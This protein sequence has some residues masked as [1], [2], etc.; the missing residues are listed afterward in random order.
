MTGTDLDLFA[1]AGDG[2]LPEHFG[3]DEHGRAFVEAPAF[4][5][6]MQY[7]STQKALQIVDTDE[8]GQLPRLTPGG[9]QLI[10]VIYEDGIW[11]LIFR[12]TLP[13]AKSIKAR[14][15]AILRE[16]R[17]T[18]VV[19]T[20]QPLAAL[21]NRDLALRI[22]AEADRADAAEAV[23]AVLAPAASAWEIFR[24]TGA[25]VTVG[26]AAKFLIQNADK[27]TGRTRLYETLREL[28]W[29]FKR[30]REPVGGAITAGYVEIEG[31]KP[32]LVKGTTEKRTGGARTRL[33]GDGLLKLAE[34]FGIELDTG[35]VLRAVSEDDEEA[36]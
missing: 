8:K 9:Q 24:K 36:S 1:G 12:S 33:T 31:G 26:E 4:G 32:Y 3:I 10:W 2:L 7:S 29:V 35:A 17:E 13:S 14:V 21:S 28:G 11:E 5:R 19:D 23:I 22:I 27:D 18:G 16:L 20:R 15:K 34:H 30:S 25:T 6:A